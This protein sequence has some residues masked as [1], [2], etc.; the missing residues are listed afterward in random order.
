MQSESVIWSS[1]SCTA[2]QNFS[3]LSHK[4]HDFEK[5][6]D[7]KRCVLIFFTPLSEA[8]LIIRRNERDMIKSV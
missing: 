1:R 7:H 5:F 6:T 8:F 4:L 3:K 2:V